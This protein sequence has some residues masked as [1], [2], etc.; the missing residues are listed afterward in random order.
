MPSRVQEPAAYADLP[1]ALAA[2][3]T[4][5]DAPDPA[6]RADADAPPPPFESRLEERDAVGFETAVAYALKGLGEGGI[7]IGSALVHHQANGEAWVVG[8]GHNERV[9]RGS[10]VMHAEIVALEAAGRLP[11]HRYRNMTIYTTLSPCSMCCGAI[12]LYKIP[13]VVIGENTTFKGDEE[14]LRSRG[15]EVVVLDDIACKEAMSKYIEA[16][17]EEWYEDIGK[18]PVDDGEESEPVQVVAE[19]EPIKVPVLELPQEVESTKGVSQFFEDFE[20]M[21][22]DRL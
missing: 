4:L 19:P 3:L 12:L 9:Q 20:E 10:C 22:T 13:R 18:V 21:L 2:K 11:P 14:L 15:V 17:R 1:D 16:N 8:A 7:P 6:A 5:A